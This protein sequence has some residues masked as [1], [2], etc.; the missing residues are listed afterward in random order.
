LAVRAVVGPA[1]AAN[2]MATIGSNAIA[3][4]LIVYLFPQALQPVEQSTALLMLRFG[5]FTDNVPPWLA[6]GEGLEVAE[7]FEAR[8][9]NPDSARDAV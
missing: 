4:L 8:R 6:R 3:Y 7:A 1:V 9:H 5:S 2:T